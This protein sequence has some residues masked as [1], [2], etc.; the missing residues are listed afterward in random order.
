MLALCSTPLAAQFT[1]AEPYSGTT[2]ATTA[3]P[4]A[5]I[6]APIAGPVEGNAQP[7]TPVIAAEP[8][9]VEPVPVAEQPVTA[10]IDASEAASAP[11]AAP[12]PAERTAAAAAPAREAAP[13]SRSAA[14]ASEAAPAVA[15]APAEV[16]DESAAAEFAP[17]AIAPETALIASDAAPAP[18]PVDRSGEAILAGLLAALGL[19]AL[20]VGA[21]ALRRRRHIAA[22]KQQIHVVRAS[23]QPKAD[24]VAATAPAAPAAPEAPSDIRD[25]QRPAAESGITRAAAR[26]VSH[27]GAAVALPAAEPATFAE[28][29]ALL[30][31]MVAAQ[32]DRANPF[33]APQARLRRA[34]L[35][36]QSLGHKFENGRS[37]I[38]LS[39]YTNNWPELRPNYSAVA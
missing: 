11:A 27:G 29:D 38:D 34:R 19:G 2:T 16:A 9:P 33:R 10:E 15:E 8:L 39:Q 26:P 3:P 12:A 17:V 25:W 24:P 13:A 22:K 30:R 18:Q 36:I 35:I 6:D 37:W 21:F 28:R 14:P 31:R 20:G 7:A 4:P 5:T 32:P 1:P 23:A